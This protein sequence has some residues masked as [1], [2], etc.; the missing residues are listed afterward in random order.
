MHTNSIGWPRDLYTGPGGGLYTGP[1]GG[2]YT[3]PGGG[4]YTGPGGGL[5]TG[6][7]QAPYKSVM[8]WP[9]LIR[10]L[11]KYKYNSQ[12]SLVRQ[13]LGDAMFSHLEDML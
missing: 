11:K 4:L 8:P 6:P 3:G 9:V 2:L 1:G 10:V 7:S 12:L 5:Y 13:Y